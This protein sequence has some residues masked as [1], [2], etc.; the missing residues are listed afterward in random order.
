MTIFLFL[1]SVFAHP[2]TFK[3]DTDPNHVVLRKQLEVPCFGCVRQRYSIGLL[4]AYF[5]E[6]LEGE[7][8]HESIS[9]L[10]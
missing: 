4:Q 5:E 6:L 3:D 2:V 9:E 7:E 8:Y 10:I 1:S